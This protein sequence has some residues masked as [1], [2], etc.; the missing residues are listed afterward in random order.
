M[1]PGHDK[2]KRR[3]AFCRVNIDRY[4]AAVI[5]N[6]YDILL[7]ERYD[8]IVAIPLQSLVYRVIDHFIDEMVQTLDARRSDIHARPSSDRFEAFEHLDGACRIIVYC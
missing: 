4:S 3:N 6:P 5:F 1:K 8:N 7:L 2:F